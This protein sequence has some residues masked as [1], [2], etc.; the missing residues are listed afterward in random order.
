MV[1]IRSVVMVMMSKAMVTMS[2]CVLPTAVLLIPPS[3]SQTQHRLRWNLALPNILWHIWFA[4][5]DLKESQPP[6]K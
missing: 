1:K 5:P 3:P 6:R 4:I 2:M